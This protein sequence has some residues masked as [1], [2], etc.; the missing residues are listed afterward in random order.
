MFATRLLYERWLSRSQTVPL[1]LPLRVAIE[2]FGFLPRRR[3]FGGPGTVRQSG[4][5]KRCETAHTGAGVAAVQLPA[6]THRLSRRRASCRG[7]ASLTTSFNLASWVTG[8]VRFMGPQDY[9]PELPDADRQARFELE[10]IKQ[11]VSGASFTAARDRFVAQ[12]SA[13][14][15]QVNGGL[16]DDPGRT[17]RLRHVTAFYDAVNAVSR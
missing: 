2:S 14:Q 5:V 1:P 9:H 8:L 7:E 3:R 6:V 10:Q 17:N 16:I 15:S 4:D 12:R 13:I 11:R